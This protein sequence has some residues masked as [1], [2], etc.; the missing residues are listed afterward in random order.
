MWLESFNRKSRRVFCATSE[1]PPPLSVMRIRSAVALLV[2]PG[3]LVADQSPKDTRSNFHD[4]TI[5]WHLKNVD[6]TVMSACPQGFSTLVTHLYQQGY[7][8]PPDALIKT[9]CTPEG[10]LTQPV[11]TAGDFPVE[12]FVGGANFPYD[13]QKDIWMDVTEETQLVKAATSYVYYVETLASDLTIDFDIYPEGGVGVAAWTLKSSFTSAP[14]PSCTT[15]GVDEI[16]A[17]VRRYDA[18]EQAPFVVAGNWPCDA[19]DPY[20][21]YDPTGN[22]TTLGGEFELGS[23]HTAALTPGDYE[24]ELRGKRSGTVVGLGAGY[25]T[26][27]YDENAAAMINSDPITITDR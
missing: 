16:E 12:D 2:L 27:L 10:S 20:F 13:A 7:V 6:G 21:Y 17:A 8:E 11:A 4:V 24:V 15:A 19:V 18:G 22:G 3:C 5:N 25:L 14:I 26:S 9:P 23:G 1:V